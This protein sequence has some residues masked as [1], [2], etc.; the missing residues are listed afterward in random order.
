MF[1]DSGYAE[2]KEEFVPASP[3]RALYLREIET[4]LSSMSPSAKGRTAMVLVYFPINVCKVLE[5]KSAY[6]LII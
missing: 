5:F 2:G 4:T 1:S 6:T 3:E